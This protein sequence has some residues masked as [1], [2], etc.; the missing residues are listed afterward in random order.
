M[1]TT[2]VLV[3]YAPLG[4][5]IHLFSWHPCRKAILAYVSIICFYIPVECWWGKFSAC[6]RKACSED[7]WERMLQRVPV[8]FL[9]PEIKPLPSPN[10]KRAVTLGGKN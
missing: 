2:N 8:L 10:V 3:K 7:L 1:M 6:Y 4:E 5:G 9:N